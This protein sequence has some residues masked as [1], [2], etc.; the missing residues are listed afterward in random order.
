MLST[1]LFLVLAEWSDAVVFVLLLEPCHFVGSAFSMLFLLFLY[2]HVHCT[3]IW[4]E[5]NRFLLGGVELINI[6]SFY[7]YMRWKRLMRER[8][9]ATIKYANG[10]GCWVDAM[11]CAAE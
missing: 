3:M 1:L 2:V 11:L 6:F 9:A 5:E 4:N 7:K 8:A 10:A